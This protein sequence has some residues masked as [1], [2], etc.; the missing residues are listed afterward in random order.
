MLPNSVL[1]QSLRAA[2]VNGTSVLMGESSVIDSR[3][4]APDREQG[5]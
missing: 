5:L 2:S 1:R 3:Q 4:A